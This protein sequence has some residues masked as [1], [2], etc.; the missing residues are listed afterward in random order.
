MPPSARSSA[1]VRRATA[2]ALLGLLL[3]ACSTGPGT[4]SAALPSAPLG[5]GITGGG[6]LALAVGARANAPA[7]AVGP[8]MVA[9][10]RQN[11]GAGHPVTLI[12]VDGAPVVVFNT[13][14]S[15]DAGNDVARE[16]D[17]NTYLTAIEQKIDGDV[18]AK[19]A[20]V[21]VLSA[22]TLAARSTDPGGTVVLIDS[23]L[24]TMA[25]LD[26]RQ[27]I[28]AEPAQ[29]VAYLREQNLLPDLTGRKVLLAGLGNVAAPQSEPNLRLRRNIAG[30][31]QKIAEAGGAACVAVEDD[32]NPRTPPRGVPPVSVVPLP[33]VP[34]TFSACG[35]A[36]LSD[37]N[38]VGFVQGTSE[39]R[40]L[41]AARRTLG[42]LAAT[43][44]EGDLR[45]KLIGSTSSEGARQDNLRLSR[46]RAEA[47][48]RQLVELGVPAASISTEGRGENLK[49]RVDDVAPGGTLLPGPAARNR[50]VV[51]HLA[52]PAA[53]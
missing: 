20:E 12:R 33:S 13:P 42:N 5:C 23:G 40:D 35:E 44:R 31:W 28:D 2:A 17:V 45:I 52:C 46:Q 1:T 4:V 3:G 32:P 14:F 37:G 50:K 22:L 39:F 16:D 34:D 29:V 38:D 53:K 25:P 49:G 18:R 36:D 11:A 26:F 43:I 9:L 6:P 21:D 15:S 41:G 27:M 51:A 19:E 48:Q 8:A 10:L 7:P 30:I 47:V 24:Q